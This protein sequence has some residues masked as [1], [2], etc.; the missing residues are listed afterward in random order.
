MVEQLHVA[1]RNMDQRVPIAAAGLDQDYP[2]ARVLGQP[3]GEDA[4]GG[5]GADDHVIR[6][7]WRSLPLATPLRE[8]SRGRVGR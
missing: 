5:A 4:S 2:D 6:L 7:H 8:E 1:D 3:V